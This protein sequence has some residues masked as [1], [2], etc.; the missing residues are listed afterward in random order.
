MGETGNKKV[1]FQAYDG[2]LEM[3]RYVAALNIHTI[4]AWCVSR[5]I[6]YLHRDV[7]LW[8]SVSACEG[9]VLGIRDTRRTGR[10]EIYLKRAC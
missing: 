6:P 9:P 7:L 8:L 10:E 1:L 5:P 3:C 2:M 4:A